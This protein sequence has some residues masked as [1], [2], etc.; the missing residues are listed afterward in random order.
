MGRYVAINPHLQATLAFQP[1]VCIQDQWALG[2]ILH[3]LVVHGRDSQLMQ[4][5]DGP[6][7]A[8]LQDS[9]RRLWNQVIYLVNRQFPQP[10]VWYSLLV[11]PNDA[12]GRVP[13]TGC[14][15]GQLKGRAV[16]DSTVHITP[17]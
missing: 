11:P 8:F 9:R 17:P 2:L 5:T 16:G 12:P 3:P 6:G 14:D 7:Q 13:A 4:S 1:L 15:S 10:A